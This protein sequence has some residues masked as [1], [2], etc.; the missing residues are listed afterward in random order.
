MEVLIA[1]IIAFIPVFIPRL[2]SNILITPC[3]RF[4]RRTWLYCGDSWRK[5]KVG[6]Y[7]QE[8]KC[9]LWRKHQ[10]SHEM[11]QRKINFENDKY[12]GVFLAFVPTNG[13]G[14]INTEPMKIMLLNR[15]CY[16]LPYTISLKKKILHQGIV[17]AE[18]K[19]WDLVS[20]NDLA[21]CI[22]GDL[23]IDIDS[24][25]NGKECGVDFPVCM[26]MDYLLNEKNYM[27]SRIT[28]DKGWVLLV[29]LKKIVEDYIDEKQNGA[30]TE[31]QKEI[32]IRPKGQ[33][34]SKK[35]IVDLHSREIACYLENGDVPHSLKD[36][37]KNRIEKFEEVKKYGSAYFVFDFNNGV[38]NKFTS[39]IEEDYK[40]RCTISSNDNTKM[41]I[42][43]IEVVRSNFDEIT[44]PKLCPSQPS[45]S[46]NPPAA[47]PLR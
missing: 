42:S 43:S 18:G 29:C 19:V 6:F 47:F 28:D 31:P 4:L 40:D 21:H 5:V 35:I 38:R 16:D 26:S 24:K 36:Y 9:F 11:I 2:I 45:N 13:I 1:L 17:K 33:K 14:R 34:K 12:K 46:P 32:E 44:L 25:I 3:Q 7:K 10:M 15:T 37:L 39:V 8:D 27:F 23:E 30:I 20:H 22:N 41:N